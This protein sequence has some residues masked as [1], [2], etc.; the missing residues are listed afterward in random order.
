MKAV[1]SRA[2]Q[3]SWPWILL[4]TLI[5]AIPQIECSNYLLMAPSKATIT[6]T[7][8]PFL[9]Q[10]YTDTRIHDDYFTYSEKY[11][12]GLI[13]TWTWIWSCVEKKDRGFISNLISNHS[14]PQSHIHHHFI[15]YAFLHS[16]RYHLHPCEHHVIS[17]L[18]WRH[19][20]RDQMIYSCTVAQFIETHTHRSQS[21]QLT[22]VSALWGIQLWHLISQPDQI[23][24][25][26]ITE[27]MLHLW[28][29]IAPFCM[30]SC[31]ALQAANY[32][33]ILIIMDFVCSEQPL[34]VRTFYEP[35]GIWPIRQ[36]G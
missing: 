34:T 30:Y 35:L 26:G 21:S 32:G 17:V 28:F 22:C 25:P 12:D 7:F 19:L 16:H 4:F 24:Q 2:W 11:Q 13:M 27:R 36:K 10:Y 1:N 23:T 31:V 5:V 18:I 9:Q 33:L 6:S 3:S 8:C 29:T 14:Q 20:P 15:I